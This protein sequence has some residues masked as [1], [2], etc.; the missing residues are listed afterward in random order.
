MLTILGGSQ[1]SLRRRLISLAAQGDPMLVIVPEQYTLQTERELMDGLSASG[2][3]DLEVLSPSRLTERVFAAAGADSRV[4]I[5]ARGKQFALAQ[6]LL[7]NQKNLKYYESAA[8]K[9]GFIQRLGALI[10]DFKRAGIAPE[11]LSLHADSLEEGAARDKMQDLSLLYAAYQ[12]QLSAQF[13]DGEDVVESMLLRLPDSGVAR[14][15]RVAVYGFDVFTGQMNRMLLTL[16]RES[17]DVHALIQMGREDMFFPVRESAQ[18]LVK[19]AEEAGVPCRFSLLPPEWEGKAPALVHLSAQFLATPGKAYPGPAP[20]IRLYAAPSP[21]FEAHFIAQ[22]IRALNE[23]GVAFGD[24]A[25]AMGDASFAGTLSTVCQAY[26][27]PAYVSRKLPAA[28]HGA[29]RFLLASLRAVSGGWDQEDMLS[30]I[31]SGYAPIGEEDSWRLENYVLSYGIRGK[32]WLAPFIRGSASECARLEEAR[33]ALITP[34]LTLKS[35][36]REAENAGDA[37]RALYDYLTET[38]LPDR[39]AEAQE[40]LLSR[41]MAAQAVQAR[42][43]WDAITQLL[44]Q[45]WV[46]LS[47][48]TVTSRH[49]ASWLEAGLDACELSSLPPTADAVMCGEV[50]SLPLSQPRVLFLTGM[51]DG[52]LSPTEPGL[53][54]P[55]EQEDAQQRLHAYLSLTNDG[56]DALRFLDVW[57]A[58]SAPAEKLYLTRSQATQEGAALRP[59]AQLKHIRR[60]FPA[61][62]EEGGVSQKIAARRPF[63]P[64]PALDSLGARA[65]EG[66][67]SQEWL[68]AWKYLC[69]APETASRAA[70]LRAAF[71]PDTPAAPLP[72]EITRELFMERVMSVSRL[73]NFA[74]CPYKHFVEQGL[75]PKPRKEWTLTP[76][77]AG[78]FY[79]SA[80]EGFTRLLP[81]VPGWPHIPRRDCD[82]LMDQAAAPVLQQMLSGVMG[83]S[84]R[85]RAAGDKYLRVL[86]RVAWTFTRGA[87]QCAFTPRDAEVR[88]GYPGGIPPI[89][90]TLKDGSRVY[91]RGIIDRIDRYA[92]DEGVFLRVVDYKSGAEKLDPAR[93][94]W[95]AQLQLL[96]YLRAALSMEEDAQPAGAFYMY[97][98]DPLLPDPDT[99]ADIEDALAKALALRGVALKDVSILQRMDAGSP[100]LTLPKVLTKDGGFDNRA[101]L[102][103][104]QEMGSLIRHAEKTA[105]QLAERMHAG[106]IAA[107]PLCDKSLKGP[108]DFCDYAA[109]CRRDTRRSPHDARILPAMSFEELLEKIDP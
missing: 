13:V 52:L 61:L 99:A 53:L 80:L 48:S 109:I 16:A 38:G 72:R 87:R 84:A 89:P 104:L 62:V 6:A 65:R 22:E 21:Y 76:I 98:F 78:N 11:A 1:Q 18:R 19:A 56:Q 102:A 42:Q 105:S 49:L 86:K 71:L 27:I 3:F 92:G 39:L 63:A 70:A 34:L 28:S 59:F 64:L 51:T 85:M 17:G 91:I 24:M 74:V 33:S 90:L 60:L 30:L 82:A 36:F 31:K 12:A 32:M 100:P 23:S 2:F 41:N 43:V 96:L 25:V 58:L 94:F 50:G 97:V 103:T 93:L 20:E 29:A 10:A 47:E 57:K 106:E 7:K 108:C 40:S 95:G 77:D 67:M 54:T 79:H 107:A 8:G 73:E 88:F 37:L 4:R 9:Q 68:E 69:K 66:E 45:A 15:R 44:S 101:M 83:D 35:R 5:D 46:L 75:S 55:Q 14:D 81:S 26:Q